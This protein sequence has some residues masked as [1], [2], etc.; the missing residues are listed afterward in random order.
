MLRRLEKRIFVG[1]P[2]LESRIAMFRKLLNDSNAEGLD[3][4]QIAM[5]TEGYSGSDITQ[6][7][8]EAAMRP[9][10]KIIKELEEK[11]SEELTGQAVIDKINMEDVEIALH[12]TKPSGNV[13]HERYADWQSK[14]GS[15]SS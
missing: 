12:C 14:Y 10:R 2:D 8:K 1:L 13:N 5:K 9:V 11:N 3:Y 7:C 4:E 15:M 6:V